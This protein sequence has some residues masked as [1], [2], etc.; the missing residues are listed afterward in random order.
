MDCSKIKKYM[1]PFIDGELDSQK[2]PLVKEHLLT[3]PLCSWEL[4]QEKKIDCLIRHNIPKEKAPYELKEA[5]LRQIEETGGRKVSL[6]VRPLLKPV[7]ATVV[8]AFL[9]VALIYFV[10]VNINKPFPVFS[11]SVK[12]HIKFLQG[13]LI[14]D[15]TSSKPKEIRNWLQAKLDFKVMVPDL[16]SQD[17]SLLGAR[18]CTIKNIKVAYIRY[19]KNEHNISVIMFDAEGIK[20]PKA[21]KVVVN[22]KIYYLSKVK[23]YN[24]ALW[25]DDG[26]ACV[27]VSDLDETELLYLASL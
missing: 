11:E 14:L 25:I 8:I 6:S 12:D 5:I 10:L 3:C 19:D 17:V 13:N 1:Y 4:E 7:L 15:V 20:F 2:S 18:I 24:S 22:N 16:S 9:I 21:K 23:G 26:I 27:F